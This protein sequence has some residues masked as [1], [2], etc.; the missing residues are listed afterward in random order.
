MLN[1]SQIQLAHAGA[2]AIVAA[3]QFRFSLEDVV[4]EYRRRLEGLH[5][6]MVNE[7]THL[8]QIDHQVQAPMIGHMDNLN[9]P[10]PQIHVDKDNVAMILD[11]PQVPII[12]S[13]DDFQVPPQHYPHVVGN[14]MQPVGSEMGTLSTQDLYPNN[15]FSLS[16]PSPFD[17]SQTSQNFMNSM[18]P[19]QMQISDVPLPMTPGNQASPY[20]LEQQFPLL[21]DS[22]LHQF[23][24]EQHSGMQ[25]QAGF[26]HAQ[27]QPFYSPRLHEW[28]FSSDFDDQ[29]N[30]NGNQ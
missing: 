29:S 6:N 9:M 17:S 14:A 2:P 24:S 15:G 12:G 18:I 7:F 13:A 28:D 26:G 10:P 25:M 23:P 21:D 20:F 1:Q 16:I 5:Q 30:G 27:E 11:P 8:F 3:G 4:T 22:Y 19:D